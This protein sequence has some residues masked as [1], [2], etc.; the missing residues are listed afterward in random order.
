MS[1]QTLKPLAPVVFEMTNAGKGLSEIA[2]KLNLT[3]KQVSNIKTLY[4]GQFATS[5][6]EKN[7][8]RAKKAWV[9]RKSNEQKP[10]LINLNGLEIEIH[11]SMIKRV[12]ISEKNTI[13]IF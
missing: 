2:N 8:Q 12:I 9:K 5:K 4:K 3:K 6:F 10:R 11:N 7:S 1:R 13:K